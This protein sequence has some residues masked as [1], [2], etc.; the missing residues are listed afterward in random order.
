M[1][2]YKIVSGYGYVGDGKVYDEHPTFGHYKTG[3]L[4]YV[5][6][7]TGERQSKY[8][9]L[10]NLCEV[11]VIRHTIEAVDMGMVF[12]CELPPIEYTCAIPQRIADN[13]LALT[14]IL[15]SRPSERQKSRDLYVYELGYKIQ[16]ALA[17]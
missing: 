16:D 1:T 15:N 3:S 4:A 14:E 6:L 11:E 9:A 8:Y 17:S 13:I 10:S 12:T 7:V 2:R 5:C